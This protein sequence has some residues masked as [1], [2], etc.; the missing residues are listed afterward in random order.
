MAIA[1]D[2]V[3][4]CFECTEG[5]LLGR[6]VWRRRDGTATPPHFEAFTAGDEVRVAE[7]RSFEAFLSCHLG[8]LLATVDASY[9]VSRFE[10]LDPDDEVYRWFGEEVEDPSSG[11]SPDTDAW[12]V[13]EGGRRLLEWI[14]DVLET[15]GRRR[16]G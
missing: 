15:P 1:P 11:G 8:H 12:F 5:K 16:H 2:W 3:V 7:L 4:W 10:H 13:A 6:L 14:H 9:I